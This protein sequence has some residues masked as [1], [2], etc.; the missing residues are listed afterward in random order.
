MSSFNAASY[1]TMSSFASTASMDDEGKDD[2][3][4]EPDEV[5][6]ES[7]EGVV[8]ESAESVVGVRA[9]EIVVDGSERREVG[10]AVVEAELPPL[11]TAMAAELPPEEAANVV[12]CETIN[13]PAGGPCELQYGVCV[14][15]EVVEGDQGT[16]GP[17]VAVSG[18]CQQAF[19]PRLARDDPELPVAEHPYACTS[20][21]ADAFA[22][23]RPPGEETSEPTGGEPPGAE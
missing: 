18:G 11:A 12:V 6:G 2:R 8:G 10:G 22:A 21:T 15:M 7:A 4:Y 20:V 14:A 1:E 9:V 13:L 3:A 19:T 17:V 23:L 16:S 5:K